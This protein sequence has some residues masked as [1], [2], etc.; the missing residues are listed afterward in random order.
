MNPSTVIGAVVGL[1]TLVIVIALAATNPGMYFNL[2]GLAI[3]LGGTCAALFIA[4]PLSEVMR[5]FKLV[6][7]VFRHDQHDQQRD[8]EELVNMAQLWMNTD[9]H[10]VELELKKVTN[11]C[12]LYTSDGLC[13]AG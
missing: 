10:K 7:T 12:L 8:I 1:L 3:V 6:G 5:V 13:L 9:V 11:P 4:Y 2:P